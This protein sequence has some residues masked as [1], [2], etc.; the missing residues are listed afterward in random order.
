ME[1]FEK[2]KTKGNGMLFGYTAKE[3]KKNP[4]TIDC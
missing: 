2:F 4:P 3:N 1:V